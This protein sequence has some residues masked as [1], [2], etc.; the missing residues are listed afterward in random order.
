[1]W[2]PL[3][4][5]EGHDVLAI[6]ADP[7]LSLGA[8][9][10]LPVQS[11]PKPLIEMKD[12]IA[13]RTGTRK[14]AVGTYF[15]LNPTVSDL[16]EEHWLKVGNVKLLVL[17]AVTRAGGGCACPE[18]AFLKALLTH[19]ILQRDELVL[20][21]LA[22]GVEFLGRASVQGIDAF[23]VVVEPGS[24]SIETAGNIAAMA[25]DLGIGAVGAIANKVTDLGQ[26]EVI[27]SKLGDTP[28]LGTVAYSKAIQEADLQRTPVVQADA[29]AVQQLNEARQRLVELVTGVEEHA[30]SRVNAAATKPLRK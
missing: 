9:F 4:A 5:D 8:A 22:A 20:V 29:A 16:P 28:L 17:G 3:F 19:T 15:R 11:T 13:E 24:R 23:V 1:M 12:L 25:R 27:R 2:A 14:D 26:L 18:G 30:W 10:G 21:D 7:S 6:D